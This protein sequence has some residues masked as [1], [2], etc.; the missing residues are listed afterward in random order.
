MHWPCKGR[1]AVL[2]VARTCFTEMVLK[3]RVRQLHGS[4]IQTIIL[5]LHFQTRF[6][7]N[8]VGGVTGIV[9]HAGGVA[10]PELLPVL[11]LPVLHHHQRLQLPVM[12]IPALGEQ[13]H[14]QGRAP[15]PLPAAVVGSRDSKQHTP[16][17]CATAPGA[18]GAARETRREECGGRPP[19]SPSPTHL[20]IRPIYP[21]LHCL[22]PRRC[23]R[24]QETSTAA[25][26]A[27]GLSCRLWQGR[28][29][30]QR[31][32]ASWWRDP[33]CGT[34][35]SPDAV[36]SSAAACCAWAGAIGG[37]VGVLV[38]ASFCWCCCDGAGR[39]VR[40]PLPGVALRASRRSVTASA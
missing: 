34:A 21:L 7:Y 35:P 8:G 37:W 2:V 30:G 15:K 3:A 5:S 38:P 10:E 11:L 32:W 9:V 26:G 19:R 18:F 36:R 25:A 28:R 39:G 6:P 22:M 29:E 13:D 1:S 27:S 4:K 33:Q 23:F 12:R 24:G 14:A 31:R 17:A 16:R 40:L 20:P